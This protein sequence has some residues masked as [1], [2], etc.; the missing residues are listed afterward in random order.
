MNKTYKLPSVVW[1]R[2]TDYM[3]AW[4][5]R[6]LGGGARIQEQKVLCIQHIP[7]ARDVLRMESAEDT[8]KR[9]P[10][11]NT[12]SSARRNYIAAGADLDNDM[13]E[14]EYGITSKE[15]KLFLPIECPKLCMTKDGVLRPWTLNICYG[16]EQAAAM[17]RLLRKVFWEGVEKYNK[18]Y[19]RKMNGTYYPA[20][21]MIEDFC[22]DTGTPDV[23]APAIRNE[24]QRRVRRGDN[25]HIVAQEEPMKTVDVL[26][27]L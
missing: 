8:S 21:E 12:I 3:H 25:K 17:Q 22:V 5:Q 23:Y 13:A 20:I 26:S 7:G 14:K 2:V 4:L 24:W 18:E 1:L 19:S 10:I 16:K 9:E 15:L 6:E 27:L 11:I